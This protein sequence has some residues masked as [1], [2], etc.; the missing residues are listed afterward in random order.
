MNE[1][2]NNIVANPEPNW[3]LTMFW[4]DLTF[5]IAKIMEFIKSLF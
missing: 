4:E 3:S 2:N 5:I 1:T